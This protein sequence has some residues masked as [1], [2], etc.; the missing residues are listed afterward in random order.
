MTT[1]TDRLSREDAALLL[2]NARTAARTVADAQRAVLAQLDTDDLGPELRQ[3]IALLLLAEE[4][5]GALVRAL[6][7]LANDEYGIC[8]LCG[9]PIEVDRL[10]ARPDAHWCAAHASGNRT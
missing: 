10:R 6:L 8:E 3:A 5:E 9:A 1:L 7:K 4:R 2:R